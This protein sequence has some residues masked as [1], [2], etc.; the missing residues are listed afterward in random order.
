MSNHTDT[1]FGGGQRPPY[2]IAHRGA[3]HCCPEN[4]LRAFDAGLAEGADGLEF[5]V[6]LS[7]DGVPVIYHDDTLTRLGLPGVRIAQ[8]TLA[9]LQSLDAGGGFSQAF[10]GER[11]PTLE[12]VLS[13]NRGTE[14]CIEIKATEGRA[15]ERYAELV[16]LTIGQVREA[17]VQDRAYILCFDARMLEMAHRQA[18]EIR[19][20]LNAEEPTDAL[21]IAA[22]MPWLFAVDVDISRLRPEQGAALRAGGRRLMSYTC[23]TDA[24]LR[25]AMEAGVEYIIT[26]WPARTRDFLHEFLQRQKSG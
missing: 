13:R 10:R 8:K 24:D 26:N 11:M 1:T 19:S 16:R 17:G 21:K 7:R 18:P 14:L 6:Q 22:E 2:I 3:S 4:T 9:E 12:Q 15:V 20:V 5:D 25:C 23:D